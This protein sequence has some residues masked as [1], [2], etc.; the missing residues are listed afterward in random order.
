MLAKY[1]RVSIMLLSGL[2]FSICA[3]KLFLIANYFFSFLIVLLSVVAFTAGLWVWTESQKLESLMS[4]VLS[5]FTR[6][7]FLSVLPISK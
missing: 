1:L 5:I 6:L 2:V 4:S 3:V 7:A